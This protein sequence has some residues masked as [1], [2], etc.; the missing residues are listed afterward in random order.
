MEVGSEKITFTGSQGDALAAR[1]DSP[2]GPPRATA[3]FAHCFT[4]SKDVF[5]A[6]RISTALA[7][8]GI[9]VLRFDFTG[10]GM[11]GGDFSNTNFSS[12]VND[13][14]AAV[15][16]LREHNQAPAILVGHSLGGAATL[17][18]AG[19]VPEAQAVVTFGR[20]CLVHRPVHGLAVHG[21]RSTVHVQ[22]SSNP[23]WNALK[24]PLPWDTLA[25]TFPPMG[26]V[27]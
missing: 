9:A 8:Q 1:L 2:L 6:T 27:D 7:E 12:N 15:E 24:L 25:A 11:S 19:R 18:A 3:L 5:A 23:S 16:Y 10:L 17:A 4:C 13:L 26:L 20:H 21:L 14:L 22:R